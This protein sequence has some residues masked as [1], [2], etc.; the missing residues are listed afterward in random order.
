MDKKEAKEFST[1]AIYGISKM[2]T[3]INEQTEEIEYLKDKLVDNTDTNAYM[4]D[5]IIYLEGQIDDLNE[6]S[7]DC[8]T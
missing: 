4:V 3:L 7:P 1:D 2:V 8:P 6:S 5:K